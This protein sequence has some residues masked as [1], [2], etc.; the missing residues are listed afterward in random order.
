MRMGFEKGPQS[1]AQLMAAQL[2]CI[3]AGELAGAWDDS[4]G[5]GPRLANSA[6]IALA[7]FANGQEAVAK[8]REAQGAE[9]RRLAR[10]RRDLCRVKQLLMKPLQPR[11]T[12]A[13]A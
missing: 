6:N 4:G 8:L 7:A 2:R 5:A 12:R 3:A 13:L 10:G 9:S 1:L 11:I